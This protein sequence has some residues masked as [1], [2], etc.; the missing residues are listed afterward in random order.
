[1]VIDNSFL[2]AKE[3]FFK[4]TNFLKN[5]ESQNLK[6]SK[7][8]IFLHKEGKELLRRLLT[9]HLDERGVGDIGPSIIGAD[10][11]KRTHKRIRPRKMKSQFGEIEIKRVGYSSRNVSSIFPLDAMLNLPTL[12]VSY[13]LQKYLILE[14]IKNSIDESLESIERWTGV[15]L[16][17]GQA[18]EIIIETARDFEDFYSSQKVKEPS[19]KELPL[20]ILTSDGKGVIMRHED[21]REATK[22][23]AESNKNDKGEPTNNK[24]KPNSKRMATVASVY[25]INRFIRKPE[26]ILNDFFHTSNL[27]EKIKRPSPHGKRVWA[28]ITKNSEEIIKEIFEEALQRDFS[29]KKE[30]VV[31]V[32]GDLNQIKRFKKLSR[33]FKIRITIV[34]DIIHVLEYIWKAGKVLND[35]KKIKQWV[36]EKLNLILEGKSSLVASGIRRS[37]TNRKL[38]KSVREPIDVCARYLLNHSNFL[39]YNEYLKKGYPI[40]TG[41]IEGACRYLVKDRMEITGARWSLEGAEALLKL[42]SLKVSGDFFSYWEFH[43]QKQYKRNHELLYQN[44]SILKVSS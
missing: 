41:V 37:A 18:K 11:I 22:K 6:L 31:L 17:K 12:C 39:Y 13:N 26:D 35:E 5:K 14:V 34:C 40:A 42:R 25:E 44:P 23:R 30:W 43:E 16:S 33:K 10:G 38:K 32:D 9:G 1:M 29:N 3:K 4:M 8:E 28:G 19:L 2:F 7:L 20:I 24:K 27:K 36:S 15:K 21:L